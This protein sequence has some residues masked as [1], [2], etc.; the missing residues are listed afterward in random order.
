MLKS[1]SRYFSPVAVWQV[2]DTIHVPRPMLR[3]PSVRTS[4]KDRGLHEL[5]PGDED[6]LT[7]SNLVPR[8]FSLASV[9]AAN[10]ALGPASHVI[11]KYQDFFYRELELH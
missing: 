8:A 9:R 3:R 11:S 5:G 6:A 4:G 2:V 1:L 10:T 7:P